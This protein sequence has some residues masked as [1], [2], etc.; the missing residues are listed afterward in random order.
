MKG[1]WKES[2]T[3]PLWDGATSERIILKIYE[4]YH[5]RKNEKTALL[6]PISNYAD[7]VS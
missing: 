3:P 5:K 4:L 6:E 1:N 7:Q 2:S